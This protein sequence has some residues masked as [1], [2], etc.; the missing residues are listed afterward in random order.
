M[1]KFRPDKKYTKIAIYSFIVLAACILLSK[2]LDNVDVFFASAGSFVGRIKDILITF[3]YGF[4]IAYFFTP[5]V[6]FLEKFLGNNING[7][8]KRPK[9][10]RNLT[11]LITYTI[12]IGCFIWLMVYMIPTV[13]KSF[14]MLIYTLPDNLDSLS[15]KLPV[16]LA[17]LDEETRTTIINT[18][19]EL[20]IP[21]RQKLANLPELMETYMS[22]GKNISDFING[23]VNIF[24]TVINFIIGIIIS[25]YMLSTKESIAASCKKLCLAIFKEDRAEGY[26]HNMQR[27][28]I[29]FQNYVLG[30]LLDAIVLGLMC[31]VGMVILKI[32]YALVISVV[33]GITNMIPYV[34][35][36]IGTVP[37]VFIV[38]LVSPI[39]AFWLLIYILVIQQIDNYLIC[40]RLLGDPTGLSPLQ[41]LFAIA[42]GAYFGGALGMFISVPVV[43]SIKLFL[44]EAI[45]RRY[46]EKYPNGNP[47]IPDDYSNDWSYDEDDIDTEINNNI[48]DTDSTI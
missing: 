13:G 34:G 2:F 44:S 16:Y 32:P 7:L 25:F 14:S 43:A 4:C 24:S 3:I 22:E 26:I 42:I 36:F 45:N 12:F 8:R 41:V 15:E 6:N 23:T 37:A 40:P 10:L 29:I 48:D 9:A 18:I 47:D 38:L 5:L 21:L 27:V 1:R 46:R 28:N 39:K 19:M 17:K 30:K 20:I 33:I 35:P 11:I 31:F